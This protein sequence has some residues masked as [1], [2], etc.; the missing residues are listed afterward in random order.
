MLSL[1]DAGTVVKR[2]DWMYVGQVRENTETKHGRGIC[3]VTRGLWKGDRYEGE[4]CENKMHGNGVYTWA[5]GNHYEGGFRNG[6]QHGHGIHAWKDGRLYDGEWREDRRHGR[7]V[8]WHPDGRIFDGAW[9]NDFPLR[10]TAMDADGKL[11]LLNYDGS[12]YEWAGWGK[13]EREP[14]GRV[15]DGRPPRGGGGR[16]SGTV[17]DVAG[18]QYKGELRCLRMCGAGVLTEGGERFQVEQAEEGAA[19]L[20]E[21]DANGL[22][23]A[24]VRNKVRA[25]AAARSST[26]G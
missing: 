18:R 16:W 11:S 3:T 9:A 13:A 17:E 4:F 23:P 6:K 20:A 8:V 1:G 12:T 5:D 22:T 15:T 10:G 19:S 14:A 2:T 7:G 21:G 24:S 26:A 25:R